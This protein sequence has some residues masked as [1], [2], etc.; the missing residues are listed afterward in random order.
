MDYNFHSTDQSFFIQQ[1][2][3]ILPETEWLFRL[4]PARIL[5]M[6]YNMGGVIDNFF[7]Y[8]S[9]TGEKYDIV[10]ITRVC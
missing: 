1:R 9:K 10:L 2:Q 3:L 4:D 7:K 6:F 5:S 8:L